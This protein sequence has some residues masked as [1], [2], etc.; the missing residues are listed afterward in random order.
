MSRPS[1]GPS[2]GTSEATVCVTLRILVPM[3]QRELTGWGAFRRPAVILV[4]E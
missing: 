1:R 2:G 3:A 4:T